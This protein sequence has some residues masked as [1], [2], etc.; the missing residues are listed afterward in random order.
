MDD[1]HNTQAPE[2]QREAHLLA[3]LRPMAATLPESG[4]MT[5]IN[6]GSE[7]AGVVPFWVGE[8][9]APTPAFIAEAAIEALRQGHTFYTYQ[10]GIPQLRQAVAAYVRRHFLADCCHPRRHFLADGGEP[11]R[12]FLANGRKF[13][14]G[15]IAEVQKL[16]PELLELT[17][18]RGNLSGQAV[19][20]VHGVL[21][22][23]QA[24][25]QRRLRH[26]VLPD[27]SGD[28]VHVR[29]S[30]GVHFEPEGGDWIAR[31]ILRDVREVYDVTSWKKRR[32]T[33]DE[34]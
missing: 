5:V 7:Q 34:A 29:A 17:S 27:A 32:Q 4:I 25:D 14:T 26:V 12:H 8:G 20:T 28:L 11:G 33:R 9:D 23:F 19:G 10:R 2:A 30:D 6:Y 31:E 16:S 13:T 22:C 1:A 24:L 18:D 15:P 3:A 21:Q